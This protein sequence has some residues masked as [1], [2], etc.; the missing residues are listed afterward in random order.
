MQKKSKK[1]AIIDAFAGITQKRDN[2]YTSPSVI[3]PYRRI[4][5]TSEFIDEQPKEK[6]PALINGKLSMGERNLPNRVRNTNANPGLINVSPEFDLLSIAGALKNMPKVLKPNIK[7]TADIVNNTISMTKKDL[8]SASDIAYE[9][10]N[11]SEKIARFTGSKNGKDIFVNGIEVS[12]N[13]RRKGVASKIYSDIANELKQTGGSLYSRSTQHQ[14]TDVDNL[15]RA[16]APAEKLWSNLVA[17]GK[18]EKIKEPMSWLYKH[19]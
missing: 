19:K 1:N 16:I 14:F 17:L 7:K 4:N 13:M 5:T 11:G 9:F 10:Y 8:S 2:T 15:G 3:S 6:K 18:A 12:D